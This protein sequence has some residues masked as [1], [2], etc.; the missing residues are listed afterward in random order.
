MINFICKLLNYNEIERL[1]EKLDAHIVREG[2]LVSENFKLKNK[3]A[4]LRDEILLEA[5]GDCLFPEQ[6]QAAYVNERIAVNARAYTNA[7]VHGF[8]NARVI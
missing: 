3:L 2:C 1:N 8:G 4:K 6:D 5:G 7:Q